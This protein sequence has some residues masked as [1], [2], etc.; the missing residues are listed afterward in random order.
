M[1]TESVELW[2]Q[3]IAQADFFLA[4]KMGGE[5]KNR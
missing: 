1:E 3:Q 4:G 5:G 2:G